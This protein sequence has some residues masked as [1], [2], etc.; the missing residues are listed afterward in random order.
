M[1]LGEVVLLAFRAGVNHA[2]VYL[3]RLRKRPIL[4]DALEDLDQPSPDVV[5]DVIRKALTR[6]SDGEILG[7]HEL[8]TLAEVTGIDIEVWRRLQK[9]TPQGD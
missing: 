3:A 9:N 2:I 7:E 4:D 5:L 8:D 6:I 1:A